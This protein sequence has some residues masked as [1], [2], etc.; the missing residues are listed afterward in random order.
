MRYQIILRAH[1]EH[2]GVVSESMFPS[3][4]PAESSAYEEEFIDRLDRRGVSFVR[5]TK[6]IA[7]DRST[8]SLGSYIGVQRGFEI[9]YAE[10][11]RLYARL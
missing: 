9:P 5:V 7:L 10:V 6:D 11:E 4:T 2:G 8:P 3:C 1:D